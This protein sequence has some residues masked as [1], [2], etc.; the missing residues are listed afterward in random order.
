MRQEVKG[1]LTGFPGEVETVSNLARDSGTVEHIPELV[2]AQLLTLK[3]TI[4][5][6]TGVDICILGSY[7]PTLVLHPPLSKSPTLVTHQDYT[8]VNIQL[9]QLTHLTRC[10]PWSKHIHTPIYIYSTI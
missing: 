8:G 5:F 10:L 9:D 3:H 7:R 4:Y 2:H 6:F 1:S